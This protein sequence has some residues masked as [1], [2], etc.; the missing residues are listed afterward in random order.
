MKTSEDAYETIVAVNS[1][2]E[3][4]HSWHFIIENYIQDEDIFLGVALPDLNFYERPPETGKFWG[5]LCSNGKKFCP[6][7]TFR[8][9]ATSAKT[10]DIVAAQLKFQNGVGELSFQKN[11]EDLGVAFN[12]VPPNVRPAI[13]MYYTNAQVRIGWGN[14][15]N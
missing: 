12:N 7:Y 15:N 9:Y 2:H 6:E 1:L 14:P 4:T 8:R 11:G 10:G 3:G 5:Y 13:C